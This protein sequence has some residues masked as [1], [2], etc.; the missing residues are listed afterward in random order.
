MASVAPGPAVTK[1]FT[2]APLLGFVPVAAEFKLFDI[3][4]T[5]G[6]PATVDQVIDAYKGSYGDG[7]ALVPDDTL[8]A[9][10]GLGLVESPAENTFS[11][12]ALTQHLVAHPSALHG[13]IHFATEMLLASAFLLPK[14]RATNFAYPF[15]ERETPFQFAHSQMGNE[16][17]AKSHMYSVMAEC[18]RMAS[19]N[20]FMTGK[21]FA[22]ED[23]AARLQNLGYDIRAVLQNP[24][25]PATAI[26]MVDVGGGRGELLLHLRDAL[27][28]LNLTEQDLVVQEFNPD[29]GLTPGVTVMQW[30]YK[31]EAEAEEQPIKGAVIYH[32]AHVLHNLPDADAI[33]L[34]AKLRAAMAPY[35]RVL[36]HEFKRSTHMAFLHAAM[37]VAMGGRERSAEEFALLAREAG[38]R[39]AFQAFPERGD[40]VVELRV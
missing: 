26:K 38:L 35:S 32:L 12:N 4:V 10:A 7:K 1:I 18:G 30:D 29:L 23:N 19:F 14:L 3:L 9:M 34:L 13:G 40:G 20:T 8:H 22:V 15:R 5:Y 37:I 36:V 24:D 21:F 16:R 6:Q 33:R 17:F 39:V 2:S 31:A 25:I 28:D 27:S 11:A